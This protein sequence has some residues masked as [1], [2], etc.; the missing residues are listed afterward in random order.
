MVICY[1]RIDFVKKGKLIIFINKISVNNKLQGRDIFGPSHKLSLITEILSIYLSIQIIQF[2][3]E[4]IYT[5]LFQVKRDMNEN[6]FSGIDYLMVI[7]GLFSIIFWTMKATAEAVWA[8]R[9][10]AVND[11]LFQYLT[12]TALK[13]YHLPFT[14]MFQIYLFATL[15]MKQ[16]RR[17]SFKS[18]LSTF[19]LV[20][21][22]MFSAL[23]IFFNL[24]INEYTFYIEDLVKEA[25]LSTVL[26]VLYV[27]GSPI[28]LG[29]SLH[30][31]VHFFMLHDQMSLYQ[32]IYAGDGGDESGGNGD[33]QA[34]IDDD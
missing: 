11:H 16:V 9:A 2:T 32:H 6:E 27:T 24:V 4:I 12:W 23:A 8:V 15:N 22:L 26:Q 21:F 34:L 1:S 19:F 10:Y 14:Q 5:Y 30:I 33:I 3:V 29:F 13:D 17:Q 25:D 31:F 7:M 20:P 28:G 18:D